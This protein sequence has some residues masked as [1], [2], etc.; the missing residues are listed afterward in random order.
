M[1]MRRM[2]I[3]RAVVEEYGPTRGCPGCQQVVNGAI[4]SCIGPHHNDK[5]RE[6]MEEKLMMQDTEGSDRVSTV[7]W[8]RSV[9]CARHEPCSDD[10]T[11]FSTRIHVILCILASGRT[12]AV[13]LT[14][15]ILAL[16][17][18]DSSTTAKC[19][20]T[21]AIASFEIFR[22]M[23]G[24]LFASGQRM[25]QFTESS[26]SCQPSRLVFVETQWTAQFD[27]QVRCFG[28]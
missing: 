6:H 24:R 5:W 12:L 27:H 3:R 25:H 10:H 18:Q 9:Q 8:R 15:S 14:T 4:P 11:N 26:L 2:Y 19:D 20:T 21:L 28:H 17:C 16:S 22:Q 7:F 23:S 13:M 1:Q